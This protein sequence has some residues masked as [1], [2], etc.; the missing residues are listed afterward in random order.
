MQTKLH[1][2]QGIEYE[3]VYE[4]EVANFKHARQGVNGNDVAAALILK[5][6]GQTDLLEKLYQRQIHVVTDV[7]EGTKFSDLVFE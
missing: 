1:E 5:D 2:L 4:V 6:E 3:R 7:D